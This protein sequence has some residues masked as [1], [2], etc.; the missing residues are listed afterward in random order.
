[1]PYASYVIQ[2][3]DGYKGLL[4]TEDVA[5]LLG[6]SPRQITAK[7]QKYQESGGTD[8]EDLPGF[9]LWGEWRFDPQALKEWLMNNG[10]I[11]DL[12]SEIKLPN[13]ERRSG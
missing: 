11:P 13:K 12:R 10:M 3:L 8:P 6:Y 7:A 5:L 2:K 1:M 9:M 4:R